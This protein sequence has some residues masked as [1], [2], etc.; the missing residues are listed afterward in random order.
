MDHGEA[1]RNSNAPTPTCADRRSSDQPLSGDTADALNLINR[2][3][4]HLREDPSLNKPEW[5]DWFTPVRL[6]AFKG[7]VELKAG[8]VRRAE[9]TLSDVLARSSIDDTKQRAVI[10]ADLAAAELA[11]KRVE[12]C[13]ERLSEALNELMQQWYATAMERIRDVRRALRPWQDEQCVRELDERLYG[14]KTAVSVLRS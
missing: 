10:L 12:R 8:Q 9:K 4:S 14:W 7:N 6:G 11:Q 3:E 1:G 2:A 5:M 13:C